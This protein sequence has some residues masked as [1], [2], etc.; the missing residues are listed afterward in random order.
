MIKKTNRTDIVYVGAI[1]ESS[2]DTRNFEGT[3]RYMIGVQEVK[4]KVGLDSKWKME[5]QEKLYQGC[6][7]NER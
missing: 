1:Q 7:G 6:T 3:V 2:K 4:W 5:K